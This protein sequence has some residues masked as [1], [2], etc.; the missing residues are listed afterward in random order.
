MLPLPGITLEAGKIYTVFAKGF[1]G[2]TGG[3]A[4]GAQIIANN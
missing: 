2:G 1:V 3:Q 4:L